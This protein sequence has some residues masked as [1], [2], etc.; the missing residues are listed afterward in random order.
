MTEPEY[1][2]RVLDSRVHCLNH[3][4]VPLS[5]QNSYYPVFQGSLPKYKQYNE[6]YCEDMSQFSSTHCVY[7]EL[8]RASSLGKIRKKRGVENCGK[9]AK[10]MIPPQIPDVLQ[11]SEVTERRVCVDWEAQ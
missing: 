9:T 5:H 10:D 8:P 1:E 11:S 6:P 2:P 3:S 4:T 7:A